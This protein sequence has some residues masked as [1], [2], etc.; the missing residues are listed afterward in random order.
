[1]IGYGYGVAA[2]VRGYSQEPERR[3]AATVRGRVPSGYSAPVF[4]VVGGC[5]VAERV[6][7]YRAKPERRPAAT[8]CERPP[9]G[10]AVA[11]FE[12]VGGYG[13]AERRPAATTRGRVPSG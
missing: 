8:L 6:Q 4:E 2:R 7:A 11:V 5:R 9:L 1:M 10:Q 12:V 13:W 3:P